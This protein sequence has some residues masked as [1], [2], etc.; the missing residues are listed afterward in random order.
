MNNIS[1]TCQL[2]VSLFAALVLMACSKTAKLDEP[3]TSAPPSVQGFQDVKL[4]KLGDDLRKATALHGVWKSRGYGWVLQANDASSRLFDHSDAGCVPIPRGEISPEEMFRYADIRESSMVATDNT[5]STNYRFDRLEALPEECKTAASKKPKAV[6]EYFL[7]LMKEFYPFFK[8]RSVDW[9]QR[10][11]AAR[12]TVRDEMTDD[13]VFAVLSE[14]LEGLDDGHMTI[15]AKIADKERVFHSFRIRTFDALKAEVTARGEPE[16]FEEAQQ[17]WI[18]S[19]KQGVSGKILSGKVK[20]DAG[21]MVWGRVGG[22][23]RIGYVQ[24]FAVAG[25]SDSDLLE[26][27]VAGA[28]RVTGLM[29]DDLADTDALIVDVSIN[30]GGYDDV[31]RAIAGHFASEKVL[32]YT[33]RP[34]TDNMPPQPMYVVP[35]KG[36][37]Y[38]KPIILVTSDFTVSGGES[39]TMALRAQPQITHVGE[40]TQGA[41]SDMI[42]KLLPNGWKMT[43]S[44]EVYKDP[45]GKLW[46]GPGIP[47]TE[48]MTV[49]DPADLRNSH[50]AL[51]LALAQRL[52]KETAKP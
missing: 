20:S 27:D 33:K 38:L 9:E 34:H 50:P 36:S 42:P 10:A 25:F 35:A 21:P 28:H 13:E 17:G 24:I 6:V 37:R 14:T 32:A 45:Q 3:A 19:F 7:V 39:L 30:S 52:R 4:V 16:K 47:P 43:L 15:Q 22:E 11:R 44:M 48:P 49:F 46:E 18:K 8:E 51:I 1:T 29:V 41:L 31:S 40:S 2:C 23:G 5:D 12:A 26:D